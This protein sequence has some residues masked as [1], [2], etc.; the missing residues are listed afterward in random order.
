M[1]EFFRSS[2]PA[3]DAPDAGTFAA[4]RDALRAAVAARNL[5]GLLVSY[6][7]NRF[8]LSGFEL[9]D[10]QCNESAGYLLV[11]RDADWLAT[12]PR[13]LEA[14]Q[15]VWDT[16][17]ILVY[18]GDT[19]SALANLMRRC[20]VRFGFEAVNTSVDFA[21]RLAR[22]GVSLE[23][24]SGLVENLRR[25]KHPS[26]LAA[27][28]RSFALNHR[29]LRWLEEEVIPEP[30]GLSEME[31]SW[32][33]EKFF[34]EHGA[35]ELAFANI[36]ASG[37]NAALPHA[38]P[39]GDA[40]APGRPL[41]VDAGCR[42]DSYCSDQTRTWW[43]GPGGDE[44]RFRSTWNQVRAA[45]EAAMRLMRPGVSCAD[46]YKAAWSVFEGYGVAKF[47]THGLGHGVGLET[48]EAP[49]LNPRADCPLMPGMVVTV[50]PGL[51]YPGW[52]GVRIEYTVVVTETGVEVL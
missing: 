15:K 10:P 35:Q 5:D 16:A 14:A 25:V 41:L 32:R 40:V 44:A 42:V 39:T 45:S 6:A 18:G 1:S 11:T 23:A 4:R 38:I 30:G 13:Y 31:L 46:V 47:F 7:P 2:G 12:D 26:E 28:R 19:A 9:H 29:M 27:L 33:I 37:P 34:R 50:E 52:G 36:V 49:S 20:G 21:R 48:H 24:V 8:Y 3:G 22:P 43:V 17:H 51:Y